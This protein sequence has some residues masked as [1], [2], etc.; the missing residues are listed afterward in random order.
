MTEW[1][2]IHNLNLLSTVGACIQRLLKM[3]L[4]LRASFKLFFCCRF[5]LFLYIFWFIVHQKTKKQQQKLRDGICI[6]RHTYTSNA[7]NSSVKRVGRPSGSPTGQ[8]CE[9]NGKKISRVVFKIYWPTL[10]FFHACG[11]AKNNIL[12]A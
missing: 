9:W 11:R 4:G 12:Y 5:N 8:K 2:T 6:R 1:Q 3:N 7:L 10:T